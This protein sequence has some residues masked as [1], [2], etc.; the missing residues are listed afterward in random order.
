LLSSVA[1][2]IRVEDQLI[3][4]LQIRAAGHYLTPAGTGFARSTDFW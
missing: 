2:P 4:T 3:E 1:T